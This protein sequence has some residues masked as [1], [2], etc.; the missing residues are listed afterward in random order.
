MLRSTS[1]RSEAAA[2]GR[3]WLALSLGL[4]AGIAGC[5]NEPPP[6]SFTEFMEDRFAR[7]GTLVRCNA[8]RTATAN[9]PE[10]INARRAAAA[11]AAQDDAAQRER[12]D[13]QSEARLLAARQR[14][15]AQ[16]EAQRRA[17]VAAQTEE[18]LAYE[19]LW[20]EEQTPQPPVRETENRQVAA[21]AAQTGSVTPLPALEPI[22]LPESARPPLTSIT[23]PRGAKPL[24]FEPSV[25]TL[26]EIVVPEHLRRVD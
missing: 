19:S 25:P 18:Q 15:A 24:V 2:V 14:E 10:C 23:L 1:H 11:L 6:R 16:Q 12:R 13:A 26:E 8:D 7:E 9:D 20:E 4:C 3:R 5:V 17:E 22:A 21:I